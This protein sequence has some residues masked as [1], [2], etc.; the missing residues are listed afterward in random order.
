MLT[1]SRKDST[2][3]ARPTERER[4]PLAVETLEDRR[5]LSASSSYYN[6]LAYIARHEYDHF[7][8][9]VRQLELQSAATPAQYLAL[10]DDSRA[11]TLA[12]SS[13]TGLSPQNGL[14]PVARRLDP[15]RPIAPVRLV[16]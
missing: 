14:Q 4:R 16:Q 2:K 13:A 11:I 10:R 7:V 1:V 6:N 15:D 5:L 3:W 9:E 8:T 12:A